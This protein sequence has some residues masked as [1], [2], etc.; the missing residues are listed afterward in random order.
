MELSG[1]TNFL[2]NYGRYIVIDPMAGAKIFQIQ[3]KII[4]LAVL[5]SI[6]F[7]MGILASLMWGMSKNSQLP[8]W[9]WAIFVVIIAI[10]IALDMIVLKLF[11]PL[12]PQ[13]INTVT[14]MMLSKTPI[15]KFKKDLTRI[16]YLTLDKA[17]ISTKGS[18]NQYL[19]SLCGNSNVGTKMEIVRIIPAN[20]PE[21][22]SQIEQLAQIMGWRV[23][24]DPQ[25][26][27]ISET[28]LQS[29]DFNKH[30]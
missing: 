13:K 4:M 2:E 5:M 18:K 14:R 20:L 24:I 7:F 11:S 25:I 16:D 12:F 1:P 19:L 26:M 21:I 22:I 23:N 28:D 15:F 9:F 17:S 27:Q 10:F 3:R 30:K 29:T 6:L 8:Q